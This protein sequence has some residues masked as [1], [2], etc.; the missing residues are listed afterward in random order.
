MLECIH[1][2][3]TAAKLVSYQSVASLV[4]FSGPNVA[5]VVLVVSLSHYLV[6]VGGVVCPCVKFR[7]DPVCS[8]KTSLN[9]PVSVS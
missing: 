8:N 6:L 4:N 5:V 7:L 2:L 9:P 3:P 1:G